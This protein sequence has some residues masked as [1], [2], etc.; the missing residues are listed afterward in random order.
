MRPVEEEVSKN[1][2]RV[3]VRTVCGVWRC[4]VKASAQ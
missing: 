3:V 1:E 4:G 2:V